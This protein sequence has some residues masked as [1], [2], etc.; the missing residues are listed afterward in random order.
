VGECTYADNKRS[1]T[2]KDREKD[3]EKLKAAIITTC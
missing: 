1:A 3:L 2:I